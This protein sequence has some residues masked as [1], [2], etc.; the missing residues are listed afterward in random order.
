[1]EEKYNVHCITNINSNN[2]AAVNN[3]NNN[4]VKYINKSLST[5]KLH[6]NNNTNN[7]MNTPAAV[8]EIDQSARV[9]GMSSRQSAV[10]NGKAAQPTKST[11]G[12]AEC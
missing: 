2:A 4:Q 9:L 5:P 3:V 8:N 10:T 11:N 7:K 6:N 12:K 1:M